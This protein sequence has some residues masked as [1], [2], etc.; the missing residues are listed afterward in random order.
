MWGGKGGG[1]AISKMKTIK[2]GGGGRGGARFLFKEKIIK[3]EGGGEEKRR[4]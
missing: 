3:R 2:R 4:G 1:G